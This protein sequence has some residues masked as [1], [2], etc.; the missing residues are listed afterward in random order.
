M[1]AEFLVTFAR[2]GWIVIVTESFFFDGV[3]RVARHD[4]CIEHKK[5]NVFDKASFM[6]WPALRVR[7]D[8][9]FMEN[10]V[11]GLTVIE[12]LPEVIGIPVFKHTI[13]SAVEIAADNHAVSQGVL[14]LDP[15]FQN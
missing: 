11:T 1:V 5:I 7:A 4:A 3:G 13:E 8:R 2:I 9:T 15:V 10:K 12:V 14:H 6:L